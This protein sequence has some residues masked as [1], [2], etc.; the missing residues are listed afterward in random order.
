[1][2]LKEAKRVTPNL[3]QKITWT[4]TLTLILK[5]RW[6]S[7]TLNGTLRDVYTN[8]NHNVTH[9][10][11]PFDLTEHFMTFTQRLTLMLQTWILPWDLTGHL[12][13]IIKIDY[14]SNYG[15]FWT[16]Q[17][18]LPFKYPSE[19]LSCFP[20]RNCRL[21]R[22]FRLILHSYHARQGSSASQVSNTGWVV[23]L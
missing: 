18:K 11:L 5:K 16:V 19:S 10:S 2:L 21:F 12:V 15:H 9:R 6:F 3:S 23:W 4:Q 13:T 8:A 17:C 1:M 14:A 20:L 7:L 22:H